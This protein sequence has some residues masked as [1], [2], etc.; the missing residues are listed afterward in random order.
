M[1]IFYMT[2]CV[3]PKILNEGLAKEYNNTEAVKNRFKG[4]QA[5]TSILSPEE[6]DNSDEL[7][8]SDSVRLAEDIIDLYKKFD[9]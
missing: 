8:T 7:K 4:I 2:N 3:R 6:L 1:P 5:N 9:F